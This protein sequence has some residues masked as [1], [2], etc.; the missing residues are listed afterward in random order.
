MLRK[1][2]VI[3]SGNER[4]KVIVSNS[5]LANRIASSFVAEVFA[6]S[7]AVRL[8]IGRGV[9]AVEIK[10]DTLTVIKKCQSNVED[11]SKIGAY[12][13]DIYQNKNHF[14]RFI[15]GAYQDAQTKRHI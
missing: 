2:I 7:E 5:V 8:G 12:I 3:S 15:L 1:L 14:H 9:D 6:C 11:K 10:G 4:G 13:R